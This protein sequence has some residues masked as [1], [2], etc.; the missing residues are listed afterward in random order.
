VKGLDRIGARR[1]EGDVDRPRD[2]ALDEPEE[3]AWEERRVGA[4]L[5]VPVEEGREAERRKNLFVETL[6]ALVVAHRHCQVVD[7]HGQRIERSYFVKTKRW[8]PSV[9]PFILGRTC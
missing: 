9:K 6:A 8:N 2:A 1:R 5:V 7:L 3:L 4:P